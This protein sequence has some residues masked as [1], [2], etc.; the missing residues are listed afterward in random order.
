MDVRL[1]PNPARNNF[2]IDLYLPESGNTIIELVNAAGQ[3]VGELNNRFLVR[4][5]YTIS[6]PSAKLAKGNY[7]VK[8]QNKNHVKV[9]PLILQ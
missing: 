1:Y 8:V 2:S 4:G 3:S 5:Q 6:I 9:V 7:F